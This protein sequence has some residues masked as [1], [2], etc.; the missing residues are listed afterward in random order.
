MTVIQ[1]IKLFVTTECNMKCEY[2]MIKNSHDFMNFEVAKKS[3]DK[4]IF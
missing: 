2:C 4:Y 3:I 1:K